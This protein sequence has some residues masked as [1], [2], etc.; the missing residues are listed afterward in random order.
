MQLK[1]ER[2][3]TRLRMNAMAGG[4]GTNKA[5]ATPWEM[6]YNVAYPPSEFKNTNIT[7]REGQRTWWA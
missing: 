1:G 6:C 5:F 7:Q 2:I 3:G 4:R